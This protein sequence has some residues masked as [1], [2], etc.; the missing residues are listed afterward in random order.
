[1]FLDKNKKFKVSYQF[2]ENSRIE[3]SIIFYRN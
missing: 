3:F 1:M 2:C